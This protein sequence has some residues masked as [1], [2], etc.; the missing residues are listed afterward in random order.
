[1]KKLD[2]YTF[3]IDSATKEYKENGRSEYFNKIENKVLAKNDASLSYLFARDVKG[4][5]VIKHGK[6]VLNG[7]DAQ[8]IYL[9]AIDVYGA[10]YQAHADKLKSMKMYTMAK[11]VE[12]ENTP[13]CE[14]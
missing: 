1:M 3:L 8:L 7:N 13:L 2:E 9:F 4:A 14:L 11:Q 12:K 6:V 5:N 10:D